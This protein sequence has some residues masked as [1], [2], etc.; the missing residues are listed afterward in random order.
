M[1]GEGMRI[2]VPGVC[3][4]FMLRRERNDADMDCNK[5]GGEKGSASDA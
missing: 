2:R 3:L 4:C 1:W 5:L